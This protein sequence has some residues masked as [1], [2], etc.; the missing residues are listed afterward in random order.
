M[1][2]DQALELADELAGAAEGEIRVDA[3]LERGEAKLLEPA[4]LTLRPWLVGELDEWRAAPE[5]E[6]LPQALGCGRRLCPS[7][8]GHE[9]LEAVQIETI[10]LD[11]EL[12]ARRPGD[13]RLVAERL[14]ELGDVRLQDLRRRGRRTTGPE[15]LDQPVARHGLVRVQEQ[16]RQERT[17]LRRIQRDDAAFG[18]RFE[19]PEYAEVHGSSLTNGAA[20]ALYRR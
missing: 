9:T 2:G 17:W 6:G 3:I 15:I 10:R 14:A 13:D 19:R 12:V 20:P 18:Y 16:D 8:L 11:A 4:D 5:R 7:R 1:L